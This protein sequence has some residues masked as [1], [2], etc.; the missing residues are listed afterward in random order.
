MYSHVELSK[1]DS[2]SSSGKIHGMAY[3]QPT[4]NAVTQAK[5]QIKRSSLQLRVYIRRATG[6]AGAVHAVTY[7]WGPDCMPTPIQFV[8]TMSS[9]CRSNKNRWFTKKKK[10]INVFAHFP[11]YFLLPGSTC[12]KKQWALA[13][14]ITTHTTRARVK[15]FCRKKKCFRNSTTDYRVK[16]PTENFKKF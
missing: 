8:L 9:V 15:V 4:V 6:E 2:Q 14:D 12:L 13:S 11:V 1:T 10:K 3:L 7:P 5:G 16:H